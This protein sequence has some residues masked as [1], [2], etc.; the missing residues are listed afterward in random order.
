MDNR[1]H[2]KVFSL[3]F[4]QKH[5]KL[6]DLIMTD[7]RSVWNSPAKIWWTM[8]VIRAHQSLIQWSR[9]W[10]PCNY[11]HLIKIT[12]TEHRPILWKLFRIQRLLCQQKKFGLL[13]LKQSQATV[14]SHQHAPLLNNSTVARSHVLSVRASWL[15]SGTAAFLFNVNL[16]NRKPPLS[17][18]YTYPKTKP[19]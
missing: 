18:L 17:S 15:T 6:Y 5:D 14:I 10:A 4:Q 2:A 9:F 12:V 7:F 3:S 16:G 1:F 11:S 13:S 19:N 8:H